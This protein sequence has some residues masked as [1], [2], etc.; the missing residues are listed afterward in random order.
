MEVYQRLERLRRRAELEQRLLSTQPGGLPLSEAD[1]AGAGEVG[2]G[3]VGAGEAGAV[4]AVPAA[5][6]ATGAL[7]RGRRGA[8]WE[9]AAVHGA[10]DDLGDPEWQAST[11][12]VA[13]EPVAT[14][15][16][17]TEPTG[18]MTEPVEPEPLAP[19]VYDVLAALRPVLQRYPGLTVAVWPAG[20]PADDPRTAVR[21]TLDP[22]AGITVRMP[23]P[24][25]VEPSTGASDV[26]PGAQPLDTLLD[27]ASSEPASSE[28]APSEPASSEPVPS[29][30]ASS[31]PASGGPAR[32]GVSR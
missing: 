31:E 6:P 15:P 17:A 23:E 3:E 14:E 2:A 12:A 24:P 16:V 13:T 5:E 27:V 20:R 4:G 7:P 32:P 11:P 9:V 19:M 25:T 29:E 30:P 18:R 8:N 22:S 1:E 10:P 26:D 21:L 28:P